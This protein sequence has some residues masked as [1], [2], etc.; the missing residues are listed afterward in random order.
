MSEQPQHV[1]DA[2]VRRQSAFLSSILDHLPQGISVFDEHLRLQCWNAR[3]AQIMGV[4][5]ELLAVDARFEDL[6]IIPARRGDFGPGDPDELVEQRRLLALTFAS[7]MFERVGADGRTHLIAREPLFF[8]ARVAG[9]ITTYTDIT[10][11]KDIERELECKNAVLQTVIDNIP[12]GVSLLDGDLNLLASNRELRR[13]LD[14]PDVLFAKGPPN[15]EDILRFNAQRGEYGTGDVEAV[16]RQLLARARRPRPHNFDRVRPDGTV[17]HIQCEPLADGGSVTLYHD[18]TERKRAEKRQLLADKVFENTPEAIVIIGLDH[19]VVSVNPAFCAITGFAPEAV[20][21]KA[22]TPG[23]IQH[24]D[25]GDTLWTILDRHGS[26]SGETTARRANGSRYPAWLTMTVVR[27]NDS[28]LVTHYIAIFTDITEHK[29]AEADIRHLAHHDALT[30]LANRF[31]L[32]ARLDQAIATARRTSSALAVLFLDLDRFKN[33]NDSLGHHVGDSLLIQVAERLKG[34]VRDADTVARLGGDEF[35]VVLQSVAGPSDAAHVTENLLAALSEPYTL[36]GM[37]LHAIPS[38]GIS[39]FPDDSSDTN[40]LL[41]NADAAMYHAKALG[42]GNYQFFTQELN[43]STT[44]RL[45]LEGKLRRAVGRNEFELWYQPFLR[46]SDGAICGFEALVR[47]RHDGKLILPDKFIPLAEETGI[48]VEIG[49]WVLR[50]A[51]RQAQRWVDEGFDRQR[52][53]VNVSA[54]QL[55]DGTLAETVAAILSE[56]RLDPTLLELEITESSIMEQPEE[57]I[58]VLRDLKTLGVGIAIDDFGTGYSS[59]S[60]LKLFPLD[61]LK[62]DRSFVSDIEQDPNDAAIVTAAVSLA[63]NLGLLVVAEGVETAYQVERLTQLGCDELQ[64]YHF[65]R[66][67]PGNEIRAAAVSA[68]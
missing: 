41:R 29:Q 49:N 48:I 61:R 57:A 50:E 25:A 17:V 8:G 20:I 42:R 45:E 39:L 19:L 32:Y 56:T 27:D 24:E 10:R 47:W 63:H 43:R 53:A 1:T 44:E 4:P 60:Y 46:S 9:F 31:S 21:G 28:Q 14:L 6:Y 12:C 23:E 65:G 38:I 51:C 33:V 18:I 64:G 15:L 5:R 11:Q 54:K 30:G 66:P 36:N 35:V 58:K 37:E 13:I 22:F 16:T 26:Y 40:G 3:F 2:A 59:L 7:H 52:V 67:R 62:I 34:V 55:R 68:S